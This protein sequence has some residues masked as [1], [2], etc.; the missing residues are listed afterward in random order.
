M[1]A[2]AVPLP[3]LATTAA[4]SPVVSGTE[5]TNPMLPT[6]VR[7]T[8]LATTSDVRMSPTRRSASVNRMSSGRLAP[9]YANTSVYTVEAMW[10][11][12]IRM[13]ER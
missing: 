6:R 10:S 7:T 11:R 4:A 3:P 13:P 12:P 8:S 2:T 9:A 5:A 1:G